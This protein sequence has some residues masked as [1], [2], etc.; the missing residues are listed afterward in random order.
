[1]DQE[2][3]NL[4]QEQL[5]LLKKS[6]QLQQ[7]IKE[8]ENDKN[9]E[10]EQKFNSMPVS[11]EHNADSFLDFHHQLGSKDINGIFINFYEQDQVLKDWIQMDEGLTAEIQNN[12]Q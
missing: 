11:W 8:Q 5:E 12:Q 6:L 1:M 2:V 3:L 4:C 7:S 10:F 9:S